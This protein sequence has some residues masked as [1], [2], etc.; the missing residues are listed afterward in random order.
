MTQKEAKPYDQNEIDQGQESEA[1]LADPIFQKALKRTKE[2]IMAAWTM[3]DTPQRRED[4]HAQILGLDLVV[5]E[6][7]AIAGDGKHAQRLKERQE[8]QQ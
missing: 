6:L 1:F 7:M 3:A 2:R 5:V 4:L 8:A